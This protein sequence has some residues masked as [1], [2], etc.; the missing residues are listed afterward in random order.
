MKGKI[1]FILLFIVLISLIILQQYKNKEGM[2][3]YSDEPYD[4][5]ETD[6]QSFC[7]KLIL[8]GDKN[9]CAYFND[10]VNIKCYDKNNNLK[11]PL[12]EY[13]EKKNV[14][15]HNE[16]YNKKMADVFNNNPPWGIYNAVDFDETIGTLFDT[17]G[18]NN[19]ATTSGKIYKG[20]ASGNGASTHIHYI[21]GDTNTTISWPSG[22]IPE[23]FTICSIT[24]YSGWSNKNR[25]LTSS[26][27]NWLHGH[28]YN[29]RGMVYYEGWKTNYGNSNIGGS[30]MDWLVMCG[31]NGLNTD[32]LYYNKKENNI[33]GN[34]NP[35][36]TD[37]GGA[38]GTPYNL[39]INKCPWGEKSDWALS[40]VIIWDKVLTDNEMM[41]VSNLLQ[42]YLKTGK[43][44]V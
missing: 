5:T 4:N 27:G 35:I 28:W 39:S 12:C 6:C 26:S 42:S 29:R 9:K 30:G 18:K 19:H 36:G 34:S 3:Y 7:N 13:V 43:M 24:R 22:S 20:R 10:H 11:S 16:S 14:C 44:N 2:E 1:I 41:T 15:R 8:K 32:N 38:G 21:K 17:S 40:Y 37:Y 33:L 31:K 23:K 25:I